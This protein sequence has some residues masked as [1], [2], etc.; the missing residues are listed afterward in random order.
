MPNRQLA[1]PS[2][3]GPPNTDIQGLLSYRFVRVTSAKPQ[4]G[5]GD[6]SPLLGRDGLELT[7]DE[8]DGKLPTRYRILPGHVVKARICK[9]VLHTDTSPRKLQIAKARRR[10]LKFPDMAPSWLLA[11]SILA[12]GE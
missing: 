6:T 10:L 4:P 7:T 2:E 12:I 1:G 11:S 3:A 9:A 8:E 5:F